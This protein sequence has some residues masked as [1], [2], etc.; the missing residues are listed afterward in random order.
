MSRLARTF[1]TGLLLGFGG[2]L[3]ACGGWDGGGLY[4]ARGSWRGRK[5]P[6]DA[7]YRV[8]LPG[9]AWRPHKQRGSQVAWER[10]DGAGLIAARA[11]CQEHGDRSLDHFLD[12]LRLDFGA[13]REEPRQR[14]MFVGRESLRTRL[15]ASL[16]GVPVQMEVVVLKKNGCLFDFWYMAPQRVFARYLPDFDRFLGGFSFPV[17]A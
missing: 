10:R 16:D 2:C 17:D 12:D 5:D 4:K 8:G 1:I 11:Q 13:W 7:T 15:T 14:S 6:Y 3:L 9:N